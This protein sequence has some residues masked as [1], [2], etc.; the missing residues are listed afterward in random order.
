MKANPYLPVK[1]Q[2][3]S[4]TQ[5]TFSDLDIKTYRIALEMD[6]E[7]GQFVELSVP[8]VGE[9]PFGFASSPRE[10]GFIE[11][12]IKRTGVLTDAVHALGAG[13]YV[14]V[15]GP[16]GK[17]FPINEIQGREILIVA[18]GLGLAPLRPLLG[19]E[20]G[21]VNMLIAAR[22]EKDFLY[23]YEYGKWASRKN[24]AITQ[25]IDREEQGWNGMTGYPHE[26]LDKIPFDRQ[27]V[28]AVL[29]GP[30]VM[31]KA[32]ANR[33]QEMGVL[34]ERIL[35]TLEMRMTCGIGKCGKCNIGHEYICVDGPVYSLAEL[36]ALPDEY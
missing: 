36:A 34:P 6:F 24:T 10:K 29:C 15:R 23:K 16:F 19:Y 26:L 28:T 22:G 13:D 25:T 11:L 5:E 12:T 27:A 31:I 17:P 2:I 7:A 1:A 14:W 33:L 18:G 32:V 9:A 21:K 8:G 30:P 3:E 20:Y 4:V 35:T